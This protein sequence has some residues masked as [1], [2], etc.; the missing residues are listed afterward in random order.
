MHAWCMS[1]CASVTGRFEKQSRA[2]RNEVSRSAVVRTLRRKTGLSAQRTQRRG[3]CAGVLQ[4]AE[5]CASGLCL[6][7]APQIP[8]W[9]RTPVWTRANRRS[10]D[11]LIALVCVCVSK[12]ALR[13]NK[14]CAARTRTAFRGEEEERQQRAAAT[15]V[16]KQTCTSALCMALP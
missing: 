4:R 11:G 13:Y 2:A 8:V 7:F 15:S 9:R 14:A 1:I 12:S 5:R 3:G 16:A 10:K 6:P